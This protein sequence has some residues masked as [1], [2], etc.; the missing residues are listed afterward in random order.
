MNL[1]RLLA[2]AVLFVAAM[3]A[4]AAETEWLTDVPAAIAR[5]KSEHKVVLL[6]FTGSDWCPW[7]I[8]LKG[9]VFETPE[10]AAFAKEN[11]VLVEVDFPHSK[12]QSAEQ[13]QAN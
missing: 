7:C 6:D 13:K 2:A 1:K 4:L 10:F 11:L 9:E 5:A 12:P 3:P 8:K